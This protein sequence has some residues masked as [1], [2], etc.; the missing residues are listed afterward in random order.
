MNI[1]DEE[2]ESVGNGI[3]ISGLE[4]TRTST[5]S[6][7]IVPSVSM[8]NF[9]STDENDKP[10]EFIKGCDEAA[11]D[12]DLAEEEKHAHSDSGQPLLKKILNLSVLTV[13]AVGVVYGDATTCPLYTNGAIF[14][15]FHGNHEVPNEDDILGAL[16][17]TIY[18]TILIICIKYGIFMLEMDNN[19]EGGI[20]ALTSLV[21]HYKKSD[22]LLKYIFYVVVVV[23]SLL[24]SAIFLATGVIAPPVGVLSAIEGLKS[25]TPTAM[26]N[27]VV[28]ISAII[29]ILL[30]MC[31]RFGTAKVGLL[32]GPI[33]VV[34]C[35]AI[36]GVGIYNIAQNPAVFAAFNPGCIFKLLDNRGWTGVK[37]LSGVILSLS[38]AEPMY[39]DLGHFGKLPMRLSWYIFAF[40]AVILCYMGQAA[41][42]LKEP[43][44]FTN[45][46][47]ASLPTPVYWPMFILATLGTIIA[48]QA[49]ITG[50]FSIV[51]A[52][53]QMDFFPKTKLYYTSTHA[54]QIYI[55][56]V[57]WALM[58]ACIGSMII[59]PDSEELAESYCIAVAAVLLITAVLY[60]AA[61]FVSSTRAKW[62]RWLLA[63][64]FIV[65]FMPTLT[66]FMIGNLPKL[67]TY[68]WFP[69]AI[70]AVLFIVMMAWWLGQQRFYQSNGSDLITT[71]DEFRNKYEDVNR[72]QG[73]VGVFYSNANGVPSY[74]AKYIQLMQTLPETIVFLNIRFYQVPVVKEKYRVSVKKLHKN[75]YRVT[76]R[77]GFLEGI[78]MNIPEVIR[79][80]GFAVSDTLNQVGDVSKDALNGEVEITGVGSDDEDIVKHRKMTKSASRYVLPQGPLCAYFVPSYNLKVNQKEWFFVR[81]PK[82]VYIFMQRNSLSI[83]HSFQI[84]VDLMIELGTVVYI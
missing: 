67:A 62:I 70:S 8:M 71:F 22:G 1:S 14:S 46:F 58:V 65:A 3:Q 63:A 29:L 15:L 59:L 33:M 49:M 55:P 79:K 4:D 82:N 30:F 57:N 31:Q 77:Y 66:F 21:P 32:F 10:N 2:L 48:A 26:D 45:A 41:F 40:P 64:A 47:Y 37:M 20:L 19:G 83:T 17:T 11:I 38:G 69:A 16:S 27:W 50:T 28:P 73:N 68:G 42:L 44:Y 52:A 7:R 23:V 78:E 76:A 18:G 61:M 80:A 39:G 56:S 25:D 12:A 60:I 9:I 54:G 53:A 51:A 6:T 34:W 75:M 74:A 36:S 72:V 81:Y 24:G 35:F 13:G 84:P 43:K 5:D